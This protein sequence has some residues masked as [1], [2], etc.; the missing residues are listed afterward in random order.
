MVRILWTSGAR[1]DLDG[2]GGIRLTRTGRGRFPVAGAA[3]AAAAT[4]RRPE[5]SRA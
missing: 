1:R 3:D 2:R 4:P 5:A